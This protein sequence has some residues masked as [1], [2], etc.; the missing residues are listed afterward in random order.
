MQLNSTRTYWRCN[1]G[2]WIC[3]REFRRKVNILEYIALGEVFTAQEIW[4]E[5]LKLNI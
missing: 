1:N 2:K 4:D 5:L 3:D